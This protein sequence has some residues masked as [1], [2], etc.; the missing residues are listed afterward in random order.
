[1]PREIDCLECGGRKPCSIKM[2]Y[3]IDGAAICSKCGLRN[4]EHEKCPNCKDGKITVYTQAEVDKLT[5]QNKEM[6]EALKEIKE[7]PIDK[8][9]QC[10]MEL[11]V[12]ELILL[13]ERIIQEAEKGEE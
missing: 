4:D 8:T 3:G 12:S 2:T 9:E 7:F 13:A 6:L 10:E 11:A 1:M 5:S